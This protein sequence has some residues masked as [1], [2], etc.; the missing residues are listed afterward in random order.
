MDHE[1]TAVADSS[2]APAAATPNFDIPRSNTPEYAEWRKSGALPDKAKPKTEE[3]APSSDAP[4]PE[5]EPTQE[6]QPK[7]TPPRPKL[8]AEDRIKQLEET[9]EKIRKGAGLETKKAAEPS[10]AHTEPVPAKQPLQ[11]TNAKP[12]PEDKN[13][14]GTA[15]YDTYEDYL[16]GLTT[17]KAKELRA[18]EKRIEAEE[19]SQAELKAK[20]EDARGRYDNLDE[21]MFPALE[22]IAGDA[23]VSPVVRAMLNDSEYLPDLLYTIGGK[24][25]DLA[26]FIK[27]AKQQPGKAIRYLA[28]TENLIK[29]ELSKGTLPAA[30]RDA[31]TGKFTKPEPVAPA[32][33][34]PASASEP[35]L[36]IGSR[37]TGTMDE[38][39]RALAALE[40]GDPNAFRDWKK[41]EDKK[42]LAR[43]RGA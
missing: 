4:A 37:G 7:A 17:W 22:A 11:F 15:K 24:P 31:A 32:K 28:V 2:P 14:D 21:V 27:M 41:A 36:E 20:V 18:E 10:P 1:T 42:E 5:A 30:G 23:A 8:S 29:E 16:E 34:S 38:S 43:R 9:I 33:R 13:P 3:S 40:K 35:P 12:K 26:S 25:E 6:S 39:A 19:R